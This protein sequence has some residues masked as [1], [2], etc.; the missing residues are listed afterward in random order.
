MKYAWL[1]AMCLAAAT[2]TATA[3][4][5]PPAAEPE[6]TIEQLLLDDTPVRHCDNEQYLRCMRLERDVCVSAIRETV[7]EVNKETIAAIGN[8]PVDRYDVLFHKGRALGSFVAGFIS[9]SKT[10]VNRFRSCSQYAK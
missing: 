5:P 10:D 7:Q 2:A 8:K 3:Q 6:P 4:T 1:A 9:R